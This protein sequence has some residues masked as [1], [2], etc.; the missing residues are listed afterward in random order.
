MHSSINATY[1]DNSPPIS[2]RRASQLA[3][4]AR[5]PSRAPAAHIGY[6]T[7]APSYWGASFPNAD[8]RNAR[9]VSPQLVG[10]AT[11]QL[12]RRVKLRN[13]EVSAQNLK[14]IIASSSL[15]ALV[16]ELCFDFGTPRT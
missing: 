13:D 10:H 12:F 5:T 6:L 11:E 1:C 9:L 15:R 8:L 2:P 7:S 3:R 16:R 4:Y 14:N